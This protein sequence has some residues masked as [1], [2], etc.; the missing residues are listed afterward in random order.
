MRCVPVDSTVLPRLS[1]RLR[2][3]YCKCAVM[4]HA[5]SINHCASPADT[6]KH[7]KNSSCEV[8][9][10]RLTVSYKEASVRA[11][12]SSVHAQS[13]QRSRRI[14]TVSRTCVMRKS[15]MP[16]CMYACMRLPTV[17]LYLNLAGRPDCGCGRDCWGV[18][19]IAMHCVPIRIDVGAFVRL[20]SAE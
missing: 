4:L 14:R 10:M 1:A 15:E 18:G 6:E 13:T 5:R 19:E 16:S 8:A 11:R 12:P 9:S 3:I 20:R 2:L 7:L 17:A